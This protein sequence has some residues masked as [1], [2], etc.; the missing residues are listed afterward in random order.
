MS[1]DTLLR[2]IAYR[3]VCGGRTLIS[4]LVRTTMNKDRSYFNVG[5]NPRV[6]TIV[7]FHEWLAVPQCVHINIYRHTFH[8]FFSFFELILFGKMGLAYLPPAPTII[9]HY[10]EKDWSGILELV[11]LYCQYNRGSDSLILHYKYITET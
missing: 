9:I 3:H 6:Y 11:K 10:T 2:C 1:L 7:S 4:I 8:F 5:V